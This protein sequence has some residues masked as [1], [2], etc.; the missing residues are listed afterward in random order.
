ML[1]LD[2]V[3]NFP[4][5]VTGFGPQPQH[6]PCPSPLPLGEAVS[7]TPEQAAIGLTFFPGADSVAA[8]ATQV[9]VQIFEDFHDS[10]SRYLAVRPRRLTRLPDRNGQLRHPASTHPLPFAAAPR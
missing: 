8:P 6:T 4:T 2:G 10:N 7:W 9:G 1:G 3:Q 5:T